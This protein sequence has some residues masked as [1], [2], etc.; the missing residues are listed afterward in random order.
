MIAGDVV[1][2]L[3]LGTRDEAEAFSGFL[4][5]FLDGCSEAVDRLVTP[6]EPPFVMV[7][8]EPAEDAALRTVTF[9]EAAL[10]HA[11]ASG[12]DAARGGAHRA[13]RC[14]GR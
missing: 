12:W 4:T 6:S 7:T 9:Q 1:L 13:P 8:S 11:F 14:R 5:R 3:T 10:A 2:K